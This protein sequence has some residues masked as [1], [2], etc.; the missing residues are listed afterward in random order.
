MKPAVPKTELRQAVGGSSL[1]R[2]SFLG[3]LAISSVAMLS[4]WIAT[5]TDYKLKIPF[6]LEETAVVIPADNPLTAEKV[7]LGRTLFFDKRLSQDNTIACASC[8]LAQI[9]VYGRQAGLHGHPRPE[10][11]SQRAGIL[12]PGVQQRSILG[13]SGRQ[14]WKPNRSV[15]LQIRSSTAL[16]TTM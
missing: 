13:R 16:P 4:P 2:K 6:G 14:H 10:G 11:R 9:W 8:H 3:A 5:A 7:E 15:R 1:L 12:Q